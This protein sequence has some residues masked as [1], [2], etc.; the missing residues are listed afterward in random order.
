MFPSLATLVQAGV[1][2]SVSLMLQAPCLSPFLQ[3]LRVVS[4]VSWV[5]A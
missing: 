5:G 2:S 3:Q 4:W 1:S